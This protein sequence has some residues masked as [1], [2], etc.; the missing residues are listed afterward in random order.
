MEIK[1]VLRSNWWV[2][3]RE[4]YGLTCGGKMIPA[5]NWKMSILV[6]PL[7]ISC[8]IIAKQEACFPLLHHLSPYSLSILSLDRAPSAL[9]SLTVWACGFGF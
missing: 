1:N 3:N 5:F 9:L 7:Y 8:F 6:C 2:E 4:E